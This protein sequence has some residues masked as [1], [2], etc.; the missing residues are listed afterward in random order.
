MCCI[1]IFE[2]QHSDIK[3][4]GS[5]VSAGPIQDLDFWYHV[6]LCDLRNNMAKN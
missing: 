5:Y 3:L 6:S 1:R 4:G 2:P